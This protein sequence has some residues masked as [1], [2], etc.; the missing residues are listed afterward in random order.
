MAAQGLRV[1]LPAADTA[2]R[3]ERHRRRVGRLLDDHP[4]RTPDGSPHPVWDFLFRYYSHKPA[5]LMRWHPG[6][7]VDLGLPT[8]H[9]DYPHYVPTA[10]GDAVTVDPAYLQTRSRTVGFVDGLLR[11]TA[12]RPPR[13]NCFGMHEWAMVYRAPSSDTAPRCG[14]RLPTPMPPSRPV[15][16]AARTS[17]RSGSS[18]S[19][20]ARAT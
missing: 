7:G 11:A 6:Y 8:E 9:A 2:D 19:R 13:L 3:T 4:A 18:P 1:R 17:M 15:T 10:D 12:D 20:R 5:L 14:C 16:C